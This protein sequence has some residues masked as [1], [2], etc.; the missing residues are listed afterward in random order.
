MTSST[1]PSKEHLSRNASDPPGS[2]VNPRRAQ[3]TTAVIVN[4][5]LLTMI[6]PLATDMYV[7]GFPA[8][9]HDL[10]ASATGV[11][12][13]LTTFF[14]GMALGQLAGG[15]ISDQRGRRRPLLAALAVMLLAST[16]CALSPSIAVMMLARFVQGFS[17]GWAM[18]IGRSIVIDLA[19]QSRLVRALNVIQGAAGIAP[20]IGPL[21]GGLI[22]QSFGW[23]LSFWVLAMWAAIMIVTVMVF[24]PESLSAD[25]RNRGGQHQLR[26]AAGDV[27]RTRRFV[28][29]LIVMAFS[30]GVT[31]AYVA[32]SAFVLQSMNGLSPM[33]YSVDFAANAV[34]LATATLIAARLADRVPTRTVILAGLGGTAAAGV[35][36]LIGAL[37]FGMPLLV[38]LVGFF[39]LMT[40]QGLVGPNAGAMA[41]GEV[42]EH[43]GTGSAV[44]GFLQWCTAGVVAP[45]AGLGGTSTAVPM[46]LIIIL[47]VSGS[48]AALLTVATPRQD[49]LVEPTLGSTGLASCANIAR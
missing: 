13:T 49:A 7:P 48:I 14:V 16:L 20:I 38:A 30:M 34:G 23:R 17:G 9:G 35:L 4:V 29:Y 18:V 43:P 37:W 22:M 21:L 31:F 5:V 2:E 28:G 47:L 39:V 19:S 45:L 15:P 3:L 36:L 44:L 46:A 8:V 10:H 40:A 26:S 25:R 33:L 32:T 24:V 6:A 41:S 42:P 1:K 12:L 27:L 11:Q